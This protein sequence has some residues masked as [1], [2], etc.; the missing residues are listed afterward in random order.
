MISLYIIFLFFNIRVFSDHSDT[1]S[2]KLLSD[3]FIFFEYKIILWMISKSDVLQLPIFQLT[4]WM[5]WKFIVWSHKN[6]WY[7]FFSSLIYYL[8][9]RTVK[10][11]LERKNNDV[12]KRTVVNVSEKKGGKSKRKEKIEV[13][14]D[15]VYFEVTV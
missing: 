5:L 10:E 7:V 6:R 13:F 8:V 14:E 4:I 1:F 2:N 15:I 3:I 11:R 12:T 9:S